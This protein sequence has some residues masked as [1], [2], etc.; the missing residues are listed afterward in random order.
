MSKKFED[1]HMKWYSTSLVLGRCKLKPQ[2]NITSI[3]KNILKKKEKKELT[4]SSA[5]E[6]ALL[7]EIWSTTATLENNLADS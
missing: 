2:W 7:V 1:F 6:G 5:G 3:F 4:I